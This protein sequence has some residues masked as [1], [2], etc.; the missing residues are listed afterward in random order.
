MHWAWGQSLPPSSKLILMALADAADDMGEC[1]PRV[2]TVAQK[3]CVSSRTVQRVLKEF[4]G[5]GLLLVTPRFTAEGRQTSNGYRLA[6]QTY[7]DKLSPLTPLRRGGGDSD[8]TPGATKPRH[9][10]GDTALS[11][12]EPPGERSVDPPR[13]PPAETMEF[14]RG[15][16]DAERTA[17]AALLTGVDEQSAQLLLDELAGALETPGTIKTTPVRWFRAIVERLRQGRF[18]PTAG[19]R[20][21]ERRAVR[22]RERERGPAP[23]RQ[24]ADPEV[25]KAHLARIREGLAR[26]AGGSGAPIP[27]TKK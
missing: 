7:P 6:M 4:E 21:A 1:W 23:H 27:Q 18:A 15:L 10:G 25:A 5:T 12:H 24:T 11:P 13:Q 8:G 14:P 22:D 20:V 2:K 17:I 3:C 19:L 26:R 9:A 16:S